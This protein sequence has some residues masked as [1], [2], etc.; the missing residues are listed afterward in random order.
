MKTHTFRLLALLALA[1]VTLTACGAPAPA[2]T[3]ADVPAF[4]GATELKPGENPI[5]DTLVENMKQA[6]TM[7]TSLEQKVFAAPADAGWDAVKSFYDG[8]LG[9]SGW[10]PASMPV[11][12]PANDMF[13]LAIY[14]RGSQNLTVM[15]LTDPSSSDKFLI[16]S[17]S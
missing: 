1:L 2:A 16:Y 14:Q 8:K 4:T 9:E 7:G 11:A 12:M 3:L 10:K 17:L 5:A 13:Q 15:L 6:G